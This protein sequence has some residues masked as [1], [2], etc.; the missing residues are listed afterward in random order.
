MSKEVTQELFEQVIEDA[1]YLQDEAEALRYV[2]DAV[3]YDKAPPEDNS[4]LEKLLLLD[5]IQVNY[6]RPV[7]E[8]AETSTRNHVKAQNFTKFCKEFISEN[9]N[10]T[11]VQKILNK[12]AKHRAAL[13]NVLKKISLIDWDTTIYK[14]NSELTLYQFAR[15]MIKKDREILKDIADMVLVFQKESQGRREI[16]RRAADKGQQQNNH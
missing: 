10:E 11:D 15:D 2:I 5:H 9:N 12:L 3:P 16:D 13:I 14:D 7:F 6:F 4:I 1:T 8:K